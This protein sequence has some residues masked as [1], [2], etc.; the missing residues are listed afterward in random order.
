MSE[1]S[2]PPSGPDQ[3]KENLE[4]KWRLKVIDVR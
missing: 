1:S 3:P 4:I 2:G